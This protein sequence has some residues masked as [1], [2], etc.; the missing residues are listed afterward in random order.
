MNELETHLDSIQGRIDLFNNSLQTMWMNFLDSEVVKFFVDLASAAIKL[1]DAIGVIPSAVGV[2]SGYKIIINDM[3]KAFG[4]TTVS[5]KQFR[6]EVHEYIQQQKDAATATNQAT[7]AENANTSAVQRNTAAVNTNVTAEKAGVV[8]DKEKTTSQQ[9]ETNSQLEGVAAGK[10]EEAQDLKNIATDKAGVAADQAKTTSQ[11]AENASQ[12]ASGA[13]SAAASSAATIGQT[14]GVLTKVVSAGSKVGTAV[15][16]LGKS[17]GKIGLIIMAVE[18]A[19]KLLGAA[20][21]WLDKNVIN[22]VEHIKESV[23]E[24]QQT[25]GDAK[26]TFDDNLK[27]LTTSSD[28]KVYATLQDEFAELTRGVD[29]YG[30]NIS[31][32]SDQYE[33]Y[34][35]ICEQIVGINPDIAKGYDNVTKSIGNNVNILMQ[36]IDIQKQQARQNV[37]DLLSDENLET[38]ASNAHINI[39]EAKAKLEELQFYR[40]TAQQ[41]NVDRLSPMISDIMIL[42]T[43]FDLEYGTTADEIVPNILERLGYTEEEINKIIDDYADGYGGLDMSRFYTDFYEEM[44]NN[45]YKFALSDGSNPIRD[46][47]Q[48]YIKEPG[49]FVEDIE[50]AKNNIEKLRDGLISTLLNVPLG[51]DTYDE[52]NDSSK[53]IIVDWIKNSEIFKIN[54]KSTEEERQEQLKENKELI[55]NL[56]NGFADANIQAIMDAVGDLDTSALTAREH[57]DEI[58]NAASGIWEAIGGENNTYGFESVVD[59]QK[60]LGLDID[61]EI[62]KLDEIYSVLAKRLQLK[63]SDISNSFNYQTMSRDQM[64]AFLGIDWN[65]IGDEQLNGISDAWDLVNDQLKLS[66]V[67]FVQTYSELASGV[68]TYNEVLSQTKEIVCDNTEVTEE[69]KTALIGLVGSEAEVNKCFDENNKLIVKDATALQKLVSQAKK[70]KQATISL[71]KAQT[72]LQYRELVQQMRNS[73]IS[74]VAQASAYDFVAD[75]IKDNIGVMEDQIEALEQTI[76]QYALLEISL[77]DA[78]SAYDDYEK[79]KERDSQMAYDESALEMLKNIDEGIL[80]NETGTEAFEYAVKAIVPEEFWKD[81]DD[82]DEKIRS[83]HDYIDGNPVF[84]RLFHVD[85]ES[86]ELDINA[87]NAREFVNMGTQKNENGISVFDGESTDF[88][89]TD[90]MKDIG[91]VAEFYGITEAWALAMLTALEKVDG[92]WG[93][94]LTQINMTPFE[95]DV[96][97]TTKEMADLNAQ[98]ADGSIDLK[99]YAEKMALANKEMNKYTQQAKDRL[100]GSDGG[101]EDTSD[102]TLGFIE[103]NK[104]ATVAQEE[105]KKSSQDLIA[106]QEAYN[107][108]KD[109]GASTDE[110]EK[111]QENIDEATDKVNT[112]TEAWAKLVEKR[113]EY[114]SEQEIS[115]VISDIDK[116]LEKIGP[117]F[118]T[119]LSTYFKKDADGYYI[120]INSEVDLEELEKSYPGITEYI[121]L[122]NSKTEIKAFA[123]TTSA[124][125]DANALKTTV[126]SVIAAIEANLITLDLDEEAVNN[127][128]AQANKILEG[129]GSNLSIDLTY[130]NS[131]L[132]G[133]EISL[134]TV[135]AN[136]NTGGSVEVNGT[137]NAHGSW[138]APKTEKSL[139]GE[140]GPE[141]LVRN[142]HWTTVGENGAEFT[143]VQKGDIIFNHKQSEQLLKNGYVAGRGK[144]HGGDSAFANGTAYQFGIPS[145]HPN[146][147]DSTSLK[148]GLDINTTWDDATSTL[149]DALD[150]A[151]DS[152]N[153]FEETIDWIEIRMEEFEE[154]LGRLNAELENK[155]T[156]G[157][158]NNTL[159][160][161]ITENQKKRADALAGAAYYENYA[162]K[163]LEGMNADLV[164]AAKNGAIA[165]T[166]FTKEQDEATVNAIQNYRDYSSKAADLYTQA[167]EI[168]TDIRNSVIQKIDNIQ[169]Y[170]DAK[171]SIEDAQTEKLQNRVD[172]DE[173]SGLIT[174][175]EYYTAMMENSGKKIEYWAPLLKDMQEEF[176]KGVA[177]GTIAVG[178]VEWYEQLSKL[179]EV[180]SNIDAATIEL[181]EFQNAINDI[182]WDNFDQLINRIDYLKEETQSLIDLMSHDDLVT[183]PEGKTYK[184]GTIKY[185]TADDVQWTDEG[186]ASLGLYAQQMEIAKYQSQQYAEAIDDLT[187]DYKNGLYSENEYYEKLNELK[188]AQYDCIE[189]YYDAEDAIV[190][191]NKTRVESIKEGIEKEIDAYSELIEKQ[192]EQLDAEKDLYDFQKNTT[193]QQKNI[194]QIERQ[195]AA[196]ANDNSLSAAAKR[197][198]LEAELAE[199]QYDLQDTYYNRS[200]EDKQT[201]LDKELETFQQ[202]KEAE[203]QKWDEYLTN[204]ETLVAE[205]LGIVKANA[206]EIGVTLTEK[207]KEYNLTVSNAVLSPWKDGKVAVGEYQTTFDKSISST[208]KQLEELKKKWQEVIDKTTE[209]GKATVQAFNKANDRYASATN[210]DTTTKPTT[211]KEQEQD[212]NK[213]QSKENTPTARTDKEN[214]GV[215]LAIWMGG[216]GWGSGSTRKKNL[217]AKG[218]DANKIQQIVNQI[219]KDGYIHNGTWK[220]KYHGIKDLSLYHINKFAKGT[221]GVKED[222]LAVIDELG[223]ELVFHAQNGKLA[224][225]TKGSSVI[226]HDITENLMQL[227]ELDPS[228][229]IDQNRPSIGVH[230]EIHNT[231]IN[232]SITYGD[233]VSINEYNGGDIK[234]LEKMV[235][236]QFDK[237]TK[238]LNSALRKYVR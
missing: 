43:D 92:K 1:A 79:A 124:E 181:E 175:S 30:N 213:E 64:R 93:D 13:T 205:S 226:P 206:D 174:S 8:A 15:K 131:L 119:A 120:T 45:S 137:A 94:I 34:K 52:L 22:K 3:K 234:D 199:A 114:P 148:N 84:A 126:D 173:T 9:A 153:E 231:E 192:K 38:I 138:G 228:N 44:Y 111:L 47:F 155:P 172:L 71:A 101:T 162:E 193:E 55:R 197:K 170:G 187:K 74:N 159:D 5:A 216:Y 51:E 220:G 29:K 67:D 53:N 218:F 109:D 59:I 154:R 142:G 236:K 235:A 6:K 100:L 237:H 200:V 16:T 61:A 134:G 221:T 196:L 75:A 136:V 77:S 41:E 105:V 123:D 202:E 35:D 147:E 76:Q 104:Q 37:R 210:K 72:Q 112:N 31:L 69:Y 99:T 21:D 190:E 125:A 144:L 122:L 127:I 166:E 88:T 152:V 19:T 178:S 36:L 17:L 95:R 204:V 73:I 224:F 70:T 182:Y 222:Q 39:E 167:E 217:T 223:E 186:L 42:D 132:G 10:A 145:Y 149:S 24:L 58:R 161:I 23:K 4:S 40:T 233:M 156:Y 87:D 26:K 65:A 62:D 81:I 82:V 139:V 208:T 102:D 211:E 198:Q 219:G 227:G 110:L 140:L 168:L 163:F 85:E 189:S 179:Y 56:I 158:K 128:V 194:A 28:T 106:A 48:Q 32:T 185:W 115:L 90:D 91:D 117:K 133:K 68:E 203:I 214:Y 27:T 238:D 2:F 57:L 129:I 165:I 33:R 89:L 121:K 78:A 103:L 141:I 54:P 108:A 14:A 169:S 80:N 18:V 60:L 177:D 215:A 49:L 130:T 191:L 25:Y 20:W 230:P 160:K 97:A 188:E 201:A 164:A 176:D 146:T 116:E 143:S 195:L 12:A 46:Y 151:A 86:G 96:Y 66:N 171:T 232:L 7:T 180:Q 63:R 135:G 50:E 83:I 11:N 107:K 118:D 183:K 209:A 150:D 157:E 98:F 212:K 184:D 229:V 113:G 225:L 207:T